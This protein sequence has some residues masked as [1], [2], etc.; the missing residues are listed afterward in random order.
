MISSALFHSL[1]ENLRPRGLVGVSGSWYMASALP[2]AWISPDE[3]RRGTSDAWRWLIADAGSNSG[4]AMV[5]R[6][7]ALSRV[8]KLSL[9]VGDTGTDVPKSCSPP[10]RLPAVG[11]AGVCMYTGLGNASRPS[12]MSEYVGSTAAA[13]VVGAV[14]T[15]G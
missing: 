11:D 12:P 8:T 3:L 10:Y 7:T 2:V 15:N 6:L 9:C 14:A 4:V 5:F 13:A 1:C